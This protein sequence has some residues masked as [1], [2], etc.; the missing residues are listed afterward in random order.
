MASRVSPWPIAR[1]IERVPAEIWLLVIRQVLR[2]DV[3]EE[4]EPDPFRSPTPTTKSPLTP[5]YPKHD[6]EIRAA[7]FTLYSLTITSKLFHESATELL[8]EAVPLDTKDRVQCLLRSLSDNP[9]RDLGR[10]TRH[11]MLVCT[12][13]DALP[14]VSPVIRF[15][16][17]IIILTAIPNMGVTWPEEIA[18]TLGEMCGPSLRKLYLLGS[19]TPFRT[20]SSMRDLLSRMRELR[21]LICGPGVMHHYACPRL[22]QLSFFAGNMAKLPA[23]QMPDSKPPFPALTHLYVLPNGPDWYPERIEIYARQASICTAVTIDHLMSPFSLSKVHAHTLWSVLTKVTHVHL[24]LANIASF[25][26]F[27]LPLDVTHLAIFSQ[28]C[29]FAS[30]DQAS[31]SGFMQDLQLKFR[32]IQTARP[33]L[34][35]LRFTNPDFSRLLDDFT[36]LN[37]PDIEFSE[38]MGSMRVEDYEGHSL[39]LF[40]P[41]FYPDISVSFAA[42]TAKA[43]Q[44]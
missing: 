39:P 43:Q 9:A 20:P 3:L 16:P 17:G 31:P 30:W 40:H 19:Q 24:L 42:H 6:E 32:Q 14:F 38:M 5:H 22:D 25:R 35:V 27:P 21:T 26:V 37:F 2:R 23:D 8:Y 15:M 18:T 7:L 13:L 44:S 29:A 4:E 34:L 12:E 33:S 10:H 36:T 1:P 41:N 11:L 28:S